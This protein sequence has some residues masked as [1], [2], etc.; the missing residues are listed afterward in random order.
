MAAGRPGKGTTEKSR[1]KAGRE[2]GTKPGVGSWEG[3]PRQGQRTGVTVKR[4]LWRLREARKPEQALGEVQSAVPQRRAGRSQQRGGNWNPEK[5]GDLLKVTM[6][7]PGPKL[8]SADF[9]ALRRKD[10]EKQSSEPR[11]E[12]EV[13]GPGKSA[14]KDS[15]YR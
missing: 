3:G 1:K 14:R 8:M 12:A 10:T 7:E 5:H 11:G 15:L 9:T 6:S 4:C 2:M 13:G